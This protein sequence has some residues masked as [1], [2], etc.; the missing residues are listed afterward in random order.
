MR[1][2][3]LKKTRNFSDRWYICVR[4]FVGCFLEPGCWCTEALFFSFPTNWCGAPGV[5]SIRLQQHCILPH[6]WLVSLWGPGHLAH[7]LR[8]VLQR[9]RTVC[10]KHNF[11]QCH[12]GW[13]P[14]VIGSWSH[15]RIRGIVRLSVCVRVCACRCM[16]ACMREGGRERLQK[17]PCLF[18]CS[19]FIYAVEPFC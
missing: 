16:H 4:V 14:A 12:L 5:Y 8:S 2:T 13:D 3:D 9:W 7:H 10:R 11:T 1:L 19:A 18:C 17:L 15:I 6:L